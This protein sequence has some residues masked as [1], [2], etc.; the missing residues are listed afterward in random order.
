MKN[1]NIFE[2]NAQIP[3]IV[4]QKANAAFREIY[5]RQDEPEV[6]PQKAHKP[7]RATI[8]KIASTVVVAAVTVAVLCVAIAYF[9]GKGPEVPLASSSGQVTVANFV[10][11][12]TIRV[13][14]AELEPQ[15]SLPISLDVGHQAFGHGVDWTGWANFELN[16]PISVEGE[17]ISTVTFKVKN[18]V[19][20]VVSI[21]CPSIVKSGSTKTLADYR[22][23]YVDGYDMAG[24]PIG[25]TEVG[26]YDSFSADY[27]TLQNSKHV[28]NICNT[29]T[30]RMDIYY[31][32]CHEDNDIDSS[33]VFTYLLKDVEVTVEVT[34]TDGTTASRTLGLFCNK[35]P[36]TAKMED[37]T[38]YTY[39]AMQIFCYD[40]N[41]MDDAT[42]QLIRN[43]IA[44]CIEICKAEGV[45]YTGWDE[46]TNTDATNASESTEATESTESTGETEPTASSS[47][48][49]V[50]TQE[51]TGSSETSASEETSAGSET[52]GSTENS[53]T[54]E[55]TGETGSTENTDN[56]GNEG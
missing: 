38:E 33:D 5:T 10:E 27:S 55:T 26:Y 25:K 4:Q 51:T 16:F 3:D 35:F 9:A 29:M 23:T 39:E 48:T 21:D 1:K 43:Q 2:K 12:F 14:A 19:F 36:A 54:T 32:M 8:I 13:C 45:D 34:F 6:K 24:Q 42:K 44:R 20:E 17:N 50:D 7:A 46:P 49:T 22:S 30:G 15:T 18:A 11:P 40:K 52:S 53:E 28:F 41:A 31:L 37:G 56:T 47:E